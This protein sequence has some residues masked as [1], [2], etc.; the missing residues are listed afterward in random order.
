MVNDQDD[1]EP[2]K[3]HGQEIRP[4]FRYFGFIAS[5]TLHRSWKR[6]EG[7]RPGYLY[8]LNARTRIILMVLLY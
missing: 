2:V 1:T 5:L 6:R 8:R 7:F 4:R 3:R